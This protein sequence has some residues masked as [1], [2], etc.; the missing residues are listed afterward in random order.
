MYVPLL[1]SILPRLV[2]E[3]SDMARL[4]ALQVLVYRKMVTLDK[5]CGMG[6]LVRAKVLWKERMQTWKV[7]MGDLKF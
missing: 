7:K 6:L 1:S 3:M 5:R 4:L 2:L